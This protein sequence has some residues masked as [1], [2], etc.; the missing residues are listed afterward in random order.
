MG[1][2]TA[3]RLS[4]FPLPGAILYPGLHLP[5]HV[6]EPRYRA[7]VKD[8]LARDIAVGAGNDTGALEVG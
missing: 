2:T 3:T 1:T 6:F 5:L 4:I 8:A 7:L